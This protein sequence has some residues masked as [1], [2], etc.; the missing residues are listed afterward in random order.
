MDVGLQ[1]QSQGLPDFDSHIHNSLDS[2]QHGQEHPYKAEGSRRDSSF[3]SQFLPGPPFTIATI[4][5]KVSEPA[6]QTLQTIAQGLF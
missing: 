1:S 2:T 3:L 5:G 6:G 4:G